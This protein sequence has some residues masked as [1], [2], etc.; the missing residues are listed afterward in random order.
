[1]VYKK[2]FFYSV[3]FFFY[4]SSNFSYSHA[5]YVS[6]CNIYQK[7]ERSFFSMRAF[8]DDIFDALGFVGY[9]SDLTEKQ[10]TDIINYI[11]T[12][13]IVSVDGRKKNLLLDRFVFEGSDYTETANVVFTIEETLGEKNL[14]IKNTVLF[15]VLE[16]Q[17]NIV[18]VKI[19]NTK[20]TLTFN[21]NK[22]ESWVQI[23]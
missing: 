16:E 15:D 22:K 21:K 12:N 11:K 1:M 6:V 2:L 13:F 5:V 8:K 20:K 3:F 10:K 14:S 17:T 7:N 23:N 9:S 19:N 4:F 18:G